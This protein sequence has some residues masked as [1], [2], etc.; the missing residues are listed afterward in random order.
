MNPIDIVIIVVIAL[1]IGGAIAYIVK[2]KKDGKGCIGCPGA[3]KCGGH[4]GSCPA[5]NKEGDRE[6]KQS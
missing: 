4:C 3:S 5:N 1:I 2:N 6:D